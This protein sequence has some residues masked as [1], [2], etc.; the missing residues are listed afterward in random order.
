[1]ENPSGVF[2]YRNKMEYSF[3]GDD[4]GLHLA[5]HKRGSHRKIIV[6]GSQL[7]RPEID[8]AA[9]RVV[10]LLR[11]KNVRAGDLK[12]LII[13]CNQKGEV[14]AA[15]FVKPENFP[16]VSE[17][18][19][20]LEGLTIYHSNPKSPAAVATRL[21]QTT[22]D[23]LLTETIGSKRIQYDVTSF[24]Q[25]NLPIFEIALEHIKQHLIKQSALVDMYA[26]VGT[27]SLSLEAPA[28]VLVEVDVANTAI[29]R[30]NASGQAEVVQASS[31]KALDYI[32]KDAVI[33][34][35]PPRAGLHAKLVERLAEVRP[36]QII[37]LSCNPITQ[38][39]DVEPLLAKYEMKFFAGY[40]FFPR[41]PH[42]EALAIL[43]AR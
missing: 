4:D 31:E 26:G 12:S 2:H 33:I 37:Y 22:G 36:R 10:A 35:D 34:V 9:R 38:A 20:F 14:V 30:K 27:I 5:L 1:M 13:R 41:T 15:L 29:A 43:T 8:E 6:S 21:L 24:F 32:K 11:T 40:N 39:R 19:Q 25:V 28:V 7:A 18:G 16:D 42:I 23:T 17:A 3:F